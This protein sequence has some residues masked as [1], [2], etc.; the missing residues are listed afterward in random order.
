MRNT[1]A[2]RALT[3]FQDGP[4]FFDTETTGLSNT[5]EIVEVGVV[6]AEGKTVMESLVRPRRRIPADAIALHGISNK[7]VREA[8]TWAEIWPEVQLLFQG[9]RVGIFNADFDLRMM[10]QS[11]KQHGLH[12]EEFGGSAFCVMKMYAR[13]FGERLGI[14]NAKW[15]SL[16]NAGRQCGLTLPNS[17]RAVDD[18]RLTCAVFRHMA[19]HSVSD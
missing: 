9:R 2:E 8:P 11:H 13:F 16:Q 12:W 15:Q 1:A 7:M 18:A 14:R 6:D 4:L 10:R 19:G 17:H 5:A 3:I